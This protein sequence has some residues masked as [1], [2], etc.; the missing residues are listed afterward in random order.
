ME[1][2]EIKVKY[3]KI[4]TA[5]S[6]NFSVSWSYSAS[7]KGWMDCCCTLMVNR[8]WAETQEV[9]KYAKC[10]TFY[11]EYSRSLID[12]NTHTCFMKH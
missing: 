7:V 3:P 1:I 4:R 5:L 10:S 2:M 9:H 12:Y 8:G 6:L 11:N